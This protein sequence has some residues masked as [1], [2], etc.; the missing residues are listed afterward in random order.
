VR[1]FEDLPHDRF[2]SLVGV[3]LIAEGVLFAAMRLLALVY[4]VANSANVS[5]EAKPSPLEFLPWL[6]VAVTIIAVLARAGVQLRRQPDGA[7]GVGRVI[8]RLILL[9]AAFLNGVLAVKAVKALTGP[10]HLYTEARVAWIVGLSLAVMILA[11]LIRDA[12]LG[13]GGSAPSRVAR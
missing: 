6:L 4:A 9:G 2:G 11:G 7:W 13:A 5:D 1:S 8:G 12:A 10:K 3:A